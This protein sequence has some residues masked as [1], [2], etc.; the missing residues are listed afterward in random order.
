MTL[1]QA[2]IATA[3]DKVNGASAIVLQLLQASDPALKADSPDTIITGIKTG[4]PALSL[5]TTVTWPDAAVADRL[6]ELAQLRVDLKGLSGIP[7]ADK[8][9][10]V[11]LVSRVDALE[12]LVQKERS[13]SPLAK[14]LSDVRQKVAT[15]TLIMRRFLV[16]KA[17]RLTSAAK[18]FELDPLDV[19][20]GFTFRQNK[21]S[22]VELI[23]RDRTVAPDAAERKDEIVTVVCSS[24]LSVG[25]GFGFSRLGEK[26]YGFVNSPKERDG[27]GDEGDH[28]HQHIDH[29]Y[30]EGLDVPES[31]D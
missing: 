7:Q 12:E 28:H 6:S 23:L 31:A 2:A 4:L 5:A 15:W 11:Y 18:V 13:D 21:E 8:D 19:G 1:V 27:S 30:H 16:E 3:V 25:V 17:E 9:R 20:C 10:Y 22:K 24:N 14:Q 26:E 29:R